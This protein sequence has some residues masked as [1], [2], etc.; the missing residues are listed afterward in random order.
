MT[1][2]SEGLQGSEQMLR[3]FLLLCVSSLELIVEPW[4]TA[5]HSL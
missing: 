4:K 3:P 5:R 2:T 1:L